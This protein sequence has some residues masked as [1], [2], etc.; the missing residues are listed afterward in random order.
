MA[1][2]ALIGVSRPLLSV[3]RGL[4]MDRPGKLHASIMTSD[5][6]NATP[7]FRVGTS[8]HLETFGN[9]GFPGFANLKDLSLGENTGRDLWF[10][11]VL[12]QF[13][14]PQLRTIPEGLHIIE[15][16]SSCLTGMVLGGH[17]GPLISIHG[18][19]AWWDTWG[20]NAEST[21]KI[22]W[23]F[24]TSIPDSMKMPHPN[25]ALIDFSRMNERDLAFMLAVWDPILETVT[26]PLAADVLNKLSA[27][28]APMVKDLVRW[29]AMSH[30]SGSSKAHVYQRVWRSTSM[31]ERDRF[32]LRGRPLPIDEAIAGIEMGGDSGI[33]PSDEA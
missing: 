29:G 5:R 12:P 1:T 26:H 33:P 23:L 28:F 24:P 14:A 6:L 4:D 3:L 22:S 30:P 11:S 16:F 20:F 8:D 10:D 15:A 25:F 21:H 7:G 31:A 17:F 27:N 32:F 19:I 13:D 2:G 18:V 9:Q